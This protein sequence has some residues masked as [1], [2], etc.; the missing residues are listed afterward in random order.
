MLST[1]AMVRIGKVYGNLMI[2][3]RPT[4]AKLVDRAKRIVAAAA[5]VDRETAGGA[6]RG[7]R[8]GQGRDRDAAGRHRRGRCR[9]VAR[10]GGRRGAGSHRPLNRQAAAAMLLM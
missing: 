1:A 2:D 8:A 6:R 7:G 4:N 3:M 5:E 10:P 9:G